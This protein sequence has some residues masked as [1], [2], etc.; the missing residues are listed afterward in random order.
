[1]EETVVERAE[2]SCARE[3]KR[4]L[5]ASRR[6]QRVGVAAVGSPRRSYKSRDWNAPCCCLEVVG[7]ALVLDQLEHLDDEGQ[8]RV[9][10]EEDFLRVRHLPQVPV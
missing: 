8:V 6:H 4:K 9:G 3:E 7:A 1:M 5:R 10:R 2:L